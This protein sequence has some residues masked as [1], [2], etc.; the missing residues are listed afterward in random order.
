VRIYENGPRRQYADVFRA[1]GAEL[2]RVGGR[3]VLLIEVAVGFLVQATTSEVHSS[4]HVGASVQRS[5]RLVTDGGIEEM[6]GAGY[7]RRDTGHEAGTLER[8]LRVLGAHVDLHR[9]AEVLV[10]Q[11][12][13]GWILRH[14]VGESRPTYV[15]QEFLGPE[16][17]E[18]RVIA[19]GSRRPP[20]PQPP[21]KR[22]FGQ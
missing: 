1:L 3:D 21:T 12:G 17:E 22:R 13:D 15:M 14:L 11:Q 19:S 7:G 9:S 18:M 20:E 10:L 5:E 6:V 16:L 8:A 2:D 4:L